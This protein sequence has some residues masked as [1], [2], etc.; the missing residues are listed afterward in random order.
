VIARTRTRVCVCTCV[1][2]RVCV[3]VY[4]YVFVCVCIC[5]CGVCA[6][7]AYEHNMCVRMN[8]YVRVCIKKRACVRTCVCVYI[9]AYLHVYV[10]MSICACAHVVLCVRMCVS[11]FKDSNLPTTLT[12]KHSNH[13]AH[14]HVCA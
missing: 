1:Y 12:F 7:S 6:W 5:V 13:S 14:L 11:P 4:V 8:V 9:Y 3:C 2:V 10:R